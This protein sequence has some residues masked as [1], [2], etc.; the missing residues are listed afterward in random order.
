MDTLTGLINDLQSSI[1]IY[2]ASNPLGNAQAY[3]TDPQTLKIN[4][5]AYFIDYYYRQQYPHRLNPI[6]NSYN[7]PRTNAYPRRQTNR[8]YYIYKKEGY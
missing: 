5:D 7:N 6:R 8:R 3:I 2:K 4:L 1:I